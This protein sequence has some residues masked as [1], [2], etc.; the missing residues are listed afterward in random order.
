MV[1]WPIQ[2]TG[3]RMNYQWIL[4]VLHD[5]KSFAQANGLHVLA[6]RIDDTAHAAAVEIGAG[7]AGL[8][9]ATRRAEEHGDIA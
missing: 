2:P 5:L 9:A 4:D 8:P 7:P 6:A 1:V 3:V